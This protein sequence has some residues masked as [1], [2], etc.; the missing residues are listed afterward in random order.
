[1]KKIFIIACVFMVLLISTPIVGIP[2]ANN[3]RLYFIENELV[4][5]KM[6]ANTEIVEKQSI[7]GKLNGNGNGM[8]YLATILIKSDLSLEALQKHFFNYNV[9]KQENKNFTDPILE[10]RAIEYNKVNSE[11]DFAKY[12]V[13]YSYSV[14]GVGTIWEFDLRAH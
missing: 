14:A 4:N 5:S 1:M 6:P 9:V 11:I 2:T 10:H 3:I 8:N 13:I 12:Y 7:C